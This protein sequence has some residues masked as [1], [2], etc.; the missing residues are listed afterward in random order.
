MKPDKIILFPIKPAA[1]KPVLDE[2]KPQNIIVV[3]FDRD[4]YIVTASPYAV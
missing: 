1:P 4:E 2:A 3:E